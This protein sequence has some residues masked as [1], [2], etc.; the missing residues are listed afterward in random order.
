M[1]ELSRVK[2]PSDDQ[3]GRLWGFNV[4][5]HLYFQG[6]GR[7]KNTTPHNLNVSSSIFESQRQTNL[8]RSGKP[9]SHTEPKLFR[10]ARQGHHRICNSA[11]VEIPGLGPTS[12]MVHT[13][14]IEN[15][16]FELALVQWG[17]SA[18]NFQISRFSII[19]SSANCTARHD[20]LSHIASPCRQPRLSTA[21][22][23]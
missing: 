7:S 16:G 22:A 6:L 17:C 18:T 23:V 21:R 5:R 3:L 4:W 13:I 11:C 20:E 10:V 14:A 12:A 1:I 9:P 2:Q 8:Y 15:V 19:R